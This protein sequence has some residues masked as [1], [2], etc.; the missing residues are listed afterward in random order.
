[1]LEVG[2][3]FSVDVIFVNSEIKTL[4]ASNSYYYIAIKCKRKN[5]N[6]NQYRFPDLRLCDR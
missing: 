1:M 4:Y 5:N 2:Y 3:A 6:A